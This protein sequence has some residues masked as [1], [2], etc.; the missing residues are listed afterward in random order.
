MIN[1]GFLQ[2]INSLKADKFTYYDFNEFVCSSEKPNHSLVF[3]TKG[4]AEFYIGNKAETAEE[5]QIIYIPKGI[6]Y[7]SRWYG[8]PK[9]RFY[10]VSFDFLTDFP[11]TKDG[12]LKFPIQCI[13]PSE[14]SDK[15][16]FKRLYSEFSK[17]NFFEA[18]SE[19][20]GI[21][22][23]LISRMIYSEEKNPKNPLMSAVKF[24]N[25]NCCRDFN[26]K[27]LAKLSD[28]SESRFYELFKDNMGCTP[29]EYKNRQRIKRATA[30]LNDSQN[31]VEAVS[32]QLNFSSPAYFRR[33]FKSITGKT[34][35]EYRK[36]LN[37]I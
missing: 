33:V 28:I 37:L 17:G 8:N 10:S 12:I 20:Y 11:E 15:K 6:T 14:K 21:Y 34:P 16:A 32:E 1:K 18:V 19:F 35:N 9:I 7:I 13:K 4:N 5:G 3:L 25:E 22:G 24:I 36:N 29:M 23:D 27:Q 2:Y 30:L 26:V 31:T